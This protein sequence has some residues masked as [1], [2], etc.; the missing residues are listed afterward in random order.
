MRTHFLH[1]GH[2][3]K[4]LGRSCLTEDLSSRIA[5]ELIIGLLD[6]L[7][8]DFVEVDE[9]MFHGVERSCE[10]IFCILGIEESDLDQVA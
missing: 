8:N 2:R 9:A 4:R 3:K 6:V 10:I 1:L 7:K 5:L